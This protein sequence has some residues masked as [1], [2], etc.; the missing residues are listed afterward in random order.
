V[1]PSLLVQAAQARTLAVQQMWMTV[2]GVAGAIVLNRFRTDP[3]NILPLGVSSPDGI[4][5]SSGIQGM[6]AL[7]NGTEM[8][9]TAGAY[10]GI[11]APTLNALSNSIQAT[12]A[13]IN[14]AKASGWIMAGTYFFN[15]SALNTAASKYSK[16]NGTVTVNSSP[17][18]C[19]NCLQQALPSIF[20]ANNL[21]AYVTLMG[22][23]SVG[24]SN[25]PGPDPDTKVQSVAAYLC[26]TNLLKNM[27]QLG[28]QL[29]HFIADYN[30]N[31]KAIPYLP[32][33]TFTGGMFNSVGIG[34]TLG[35]LVLRVVLNLLIR[36][37]N[38]ILPMALD[39]ICRPII[40]MTVPIFTDGLES[41]L[42]NYTNPIIALAQ[43]GNMFINLATGVW[44]LAMIGT[45][46]LSAIPY[47][48]NVGVAISMMIMPYLGAWLGAMF[49]A[50]ATMSYYI[51]LLP[52]MLFTFGTMGWFIGVIE[53]MVA[54]P[55][56]ALGVTLPDSE[57]E[58]MG[59]SEP[60]MLLLLGVFLRPPLMI[61]GFISGIIL[62]YVGIWLLNTGFQSVITGLIGPSAQ[63]VPQDAL[64]AQNFGSSPSTPPSVVSGFAAIIGI[65]VMIILYLSLYISIVKIALENLMFKIP[66]DILTWLAGGRKVPLGE[67]T[68][69]ALKDSE[70]AVKG[71]AQGMEGAAKQSGGGGDGKKKGKA[72]GKGKGAGAGGGPKGR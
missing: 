51:P 72:K 54:A 33:K 30:V 13:F 1:D 66:D 70:D 57:H 47:T 6:S 25:C 69:G 60:A 64:W 16:D 40:E 26:N 8:N 34:M 61:I 2:D 67:M 45:T 63:G 62:S 18:F 23:Q 15:L 7:L 44:L 36:I 4:V 43:M 9:Q 59:K 35:Y 12:S 38:E 31:W 55:L 28:T 46:V 42:A 52:Y 3:S 5:W 39:T 41:A 14:G 10:L 20:T 71:T 50:G 19:S 21:D 17:A 49:T 27:G 65:I 11:M 32:E 58:V 37:L 48:S 53:A 22:G 68:K 24:R 29:P 56:V